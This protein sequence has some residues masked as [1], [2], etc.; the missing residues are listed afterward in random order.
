MSEANPRRGRTSPRR[1]LL[2]RGLAPVR[3]NWLRAVRSASGAKYLA[4]GLA[5]GVFLGCIPTFFIH[6]PIAWVAA[7][8]LRVSRLGAVVG[9]FISNPFT[10]VPLYTFTFVIGQWMWPPEPGHPL[11]DLRAILADPAL[12]GS[13]GW[14]DLLRWMIGSTALGIVLGGLTYETTRR[15]ATRYMA[16]REMRRRRQHEPEGFRGP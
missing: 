2:N 12:L 8:I 6:V 4:A 15:W 3:L 5:L 11:A 14:D 7:A 9:V 10:A 16:A 1:G 13:M